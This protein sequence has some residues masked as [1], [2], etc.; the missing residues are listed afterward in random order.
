MTMNGSKLTGIIVF[1][2]VIF[3][4]SFGTSHFFPEPFVSGKEVTIYTNIVN[5]ESR[6]VRD[7][8]LTVT[9]VDMNEIVHAGEFDIPKRDT[10]SMRIFFD[11]PKNVMKGEHLVKL[12]A[13]NEDYR[14]Q[15]YYRV[16]VR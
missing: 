10:D 2:L 15:K 9:F 14:A 12:T 4:I 3:G 7:V 5:T 8:D 1:V 16:L 13:R 11:V 6:T